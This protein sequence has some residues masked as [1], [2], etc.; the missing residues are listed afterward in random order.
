[1]SV[2]VDHQPM[3][4][5][6]M[7]LRTVG[8][9]LS[10]LQRDNRLVVH[11]LVDGEEPDLTRLSRLRQIPVQGHTIFVETADPS[12][13]AIEVL[14]AVQEQLEQTD[15]LKEDATQLL[16]SNQYAQAMEKLSG[17]FST[18]QHAQESVLKTAQLLRIDL[19]AIHADNQSLN[20]LLDTF[21]LQLRQIKSTLED[22]DYVM[23]CDILT[24]EM[25]D[26]ST[27]W[28]AAIDALRKVITEA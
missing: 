23:L 10:H 13:M 17:C 4:A 18:W 25:T 20:Q 24:Y 21:T 19:S 2:T 1:M 11:V 9:L 27:Q 16:R 6:K 5:E 3:A 14:D 8:Q 26:T 7:G 22:R 28:R 12:R 15:Q